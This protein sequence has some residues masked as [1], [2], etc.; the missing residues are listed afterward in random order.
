MTARARLAAALA[1][2]CSAC[3]AGPVAPAADGRDGAALD[4]PP[5]LDSAAPPPAFALHAPTPAPGAPWP[6]VLS[7][8]EPL[9]ATVTL[10]VGD[11]DHA[12]R[13]YR[14]RGSVTVRAGAEGPVAIAVDGAPLAALEVVARPRRP[15]SGALAGADL[16]WDAERDVYLEASATVP[17]GATLVIAAGTRVFVAAGANLDVRGALRSEGSAERPVLFAP[18]GE[19]W[20]GVALDGGPSALAWTW[21]VGGGAD[22]GR[23]FGHSASQPVVWV[24]GALGMVGG[25]VLDSPGKAFGARGASVTLEGVTVARCDTGGELDTTALEATGLHV[26]EIPDADGR[27]EDDDN[28]GIYLVAA[29]PPA[30]DAARAVLRDAVFAVGEDDA[31]DHNGVALRVERAWIAGFAHEGVAASSGGRVEIVD[32]VIA[33]CGQGVEAGYGAPEVVVE[34]SVVHGCGVGLRFG[35]SYTWEA[36]GSLAAAGVVLHGNGRDVWN[37]ARGRGGPREG[38][39][40]VACSV[41]DDPAWVGVAGNVAGPPGGAW[42]EGC[43]SGPA[44]D[45]GVC[46]LERAGPVCAGP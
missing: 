10:R 45:A 21:F 22:A 3:A 36:A 8:A 42:A 17:A 43:A 6:L 35:D 9:T 16:A 23:R 38:A 33:G 18:T 19:A 34:R 32:S 46:G 20:G 27:A 11:A 44:L 4:A 26:S 14:G 15:L 5:P 30:G 37:F 13:L 28:D 2:A 41:V 39:I 25:G 24:S 1:L 29:W 40:A 31:I 12:V 7:A